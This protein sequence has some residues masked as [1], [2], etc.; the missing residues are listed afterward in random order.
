M[1]EKYYNKS[2]D[3]AGAFA[4]YIRFKLSCETSF[5]F[6]TI[7]CRSWRLLQAERSV[8]QLEVFINTVNRVMFRSFTI[9]RIRVYTTASF[10]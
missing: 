1:S 10:T 4:I 7:S 5:P 8:R 9:C 6:S 2:T 3:T